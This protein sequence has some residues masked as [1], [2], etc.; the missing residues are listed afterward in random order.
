MEI[1]EEE[2]KIVDII[3]KPDGSAELII[4]ISDKF[5]EEFKSLHGLKRFSQRAFQK[6]VI[7]A[8]EDKCNED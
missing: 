7:K 3:S 2:L 5:K 4:R 1:I 6:F 8:L